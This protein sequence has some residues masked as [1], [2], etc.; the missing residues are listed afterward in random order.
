[1]SAPRRAWRSGRGWRSARPAERRTDHGR[2]KADGRRRTGKNGPRTMDHRRQSAGDQR[3]HRNDDRRFVVHGLSSLAQQ[4]LPPAP[5]CRPAESTRP[6]HGPPGSG[7][8][9]LSTVAEESEGAGP[10]NRRAAESLEAWPLR[11][12]AWRLAP[13]V[14]HATGFDLGLRYYLTPN[15]PH[16]EAP[17]A[18]HPS[19]TPVRAVP[20]ES[21][22]CRTKGSPR[23]QPCGYNGG[24]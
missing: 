8:F 20:A 16:W 19:F 9:S 18:D 14:L 6:G 23:S 17:I 5:R 4:G 10:A 3:R 2:R 22:R 7:F 24:K 15:C 21:V 11:L 1:M 12:R 13:S